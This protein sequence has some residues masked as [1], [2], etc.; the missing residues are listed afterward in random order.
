MPPSSEDDT[1]SLEKARE[2][3]Y[4]QRAE[5][6]TSPMPTVSETR[7]LPHTWKETIL[8]PSL[9]GGKRHVRLASIF[10]T[11][12]VFFFLISLGIAGYIFSV[13]GNSVSVDKVVLDVQGPTTI[14]GGDTVPLSLTV[15]NKNAIAIENATIDITFPTGTRNATNILQAY[16]RYTENLGTLASGASVTRSI[17]AIV[18]GGVG[19]T[20]TLP[21]SL[22][23][24]AAGSNAVFVKKSSYMVAVS[25]TPLSVSVDTLSEVVS[26]KPFSFSLTVRSNATVPLDNVVLTGLFPFGFMVTSSSLPL[27][28][29]S[30][31]LGTLKPGA[32]KTITLTG[33]LTGQNNEQRVFHF[34]LGTA[35]TSQDQTLAITYMSQDAAVTITAPFISTTLALNG[36]TSPNVIVTPN[37]HQSVTLSY[38]NTLSTNVTNATVA[39]TISGTAV[40]YNSIQTTNGFY[41]SSDHTILFSRDTDP[42]LAQLAPGASGVGTF[43]FSTLPA[44]SLASAPTIT[45]TTSVSGTRVGQSNVPEEVTASATQTAKVAT[46]VALLASALHS[47]GPLSTGGPIPP[48]VGQATTYTIMWSARN[49][50]S[51]IAGGTMRAPLPSYVSYVSKT[52]GA[53]SFSYDD[54]SRTVLWNTGDLA[55]GANPQGAF[56]VSL[57]PSTSQK[58]NVPQLTGVTSFSGYD[59]FAGVQVTA[60]VDPV[61]TETKGDPGY[62]PMNA[63]VQ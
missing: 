56:Q 27:N 63:V 62:S 53:G 23:Y 51:A 26:G 46:V 38:T 17:K 15:T 5:R 34:T 42:S 36:D 54:K 44:N 14:A 4:G 58:G 52:S 47:S 21:A 40:D 50:G 29:S 43:T 1:S 57:I 2:R 6:N 59:R 48:Q 13:G 28:N 60:T 37:A 10:F 61:T 19:Q 12:A 7:E 25:T 8:P 45:F 30:F 11:V 49:Q 32:S 22:S 24:T 3:L 18:F 33:A 31:L 55:Q 9:V 20:L 16:P 39:V 41:R 35:K